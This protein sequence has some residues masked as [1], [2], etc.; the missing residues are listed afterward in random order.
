MHHQK[1]LYEKE[2]TIIISSN[3]QHYCFLVVFLLFSGLECNNKKDDPEGECNRFRS[4]KVAWKA[5]PVNPLDRPINP[6]SHMGPPGQ[7]EFYYSLDDDI[8]NVCTKEITVVVF[9]IKITSHWSHA[10]SYKA[11]VHLG[12]QSFESEINWNSTFSDGIQ[13]NIG[14]ITIPAKVEGGEATLNME[15]DLIILDSYYDIILQVANEG[16]V[17]IE[18]DFAFTEY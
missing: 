7:G 6:E 15:V 12:S 16:F 10:I 13:T 11:F 18:M 5:T 2:Y 9:T 8:E 1:P 3:D 14:S 4:M 17:E